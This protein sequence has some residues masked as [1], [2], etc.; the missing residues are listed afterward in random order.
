MQGKAGL[1]EHRGKTVSPTGGRL[2]GQLGKVVGRG[3][4]VSCG[5]GTGSRTTGRWTELG[6]AVDRIWEMSLVVL[7]FTGQWWRGRCP[8]G[9]EVLQ[10][11]PR[12]GVRPEKQ[13]R[14]SAAL[15]GYV[16]HGRVE[17][18][19]LPTCLSPHSTYMCQAPWL[20]S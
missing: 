6:S 14:E 19:I 10:R 13:P 15:E 16:C 8:W 9:A 3:S 12:A 20:R 4:G 2:R 11:Q 5:T 18:T 17:V 7:W 1:D